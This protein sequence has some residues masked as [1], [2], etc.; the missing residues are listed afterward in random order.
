MG[1]VLAQA[2]MGGGPHRPGETADGLLGCSRRM[3]ANSTTA[4]DGVVRKCRVPMGLAGTWNPLG[5]GASEQFQGLQRVLEFLPPSL[6]LAAA[7]VTGWPD[8]RALWQASQGSAQ[9]RL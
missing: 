5:K 7:R 9:L 3:A 2:E 6:H 4:W 1:L 8:R